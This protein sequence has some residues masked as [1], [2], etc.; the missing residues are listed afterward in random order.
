MTGQPADA[1]E[2]LQDRTATTVRDAMDGVVLSVLNGSSS[3]QAQAKL[4]E[5]VVRAAAMADMLGRYAL[6]KEFDAKVGRRSYSDEPTPLVP[7]VPFDEA[8]D[9]LLSRDPRLAT[10]WEEVQAIYTMDHGFSLARAMTQQLTDKV[11]L[12]L[13]QS[14]D[15]GSSA[16]DAEQQLRF[17]ASAHDVGFT[18][19][20]AQTVYRTNLNSAYTAGR[21]RQAKA[22]GVRSVAPGFRYDAV[23]D[24]DVRPNHR[25]LDG[26]V[27]LQNDPVWQ[28]CSPPLGFN[29]RCTL[30]LALRSEVEAAGLLRGGRARARTKPA[31]AGPDPGFTKV[32][33][34]D[35]EVYPPGPALPL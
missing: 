8:I 22:P 27:A 12:F 28:Q 16:L 32:N 6:L 24:D 25:A 7:A 10:G 1:L 2:Q 5:A 3:K 23:M 9:A 18:R 29:C 15:Q 20:Y 34:T 19:G 21:M 14:M 35:A 17:L 26:F 31:G 4:G 30:A 13:A 33:R 11:Q